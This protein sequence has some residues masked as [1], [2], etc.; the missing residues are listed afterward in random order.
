MT[1]RK[2]IFN[3]L[4]GIDQLGNAITGG[5]PDETISSRAAKGQFKGKWWGRWLCK[6][7]DIVDPGHCPDAIEKDE[8]D[9]L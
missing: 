4:I 5:D 7:L 2:W 6:A 3:V 1:L 8:G 9:K